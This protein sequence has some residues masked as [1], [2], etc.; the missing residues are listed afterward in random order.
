MVRVTLVNGV[1]DLFF[2]I[3]SLEPVEFVNETSLS[4]SYYGTRV[5][6]QVSSS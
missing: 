5:V 4:D 1:F 3:T 6:A 2:F